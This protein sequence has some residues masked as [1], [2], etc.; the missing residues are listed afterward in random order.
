MEAGRPEAAAAIWNWR[1]D[2]QASAPSARSARWRG[3]LR[4]ALVASVGLLLFAFWSTRVGA[5][6]CIVAGVIL[7]SALVSPTGL[8]AGVE[9]LF[10]ALGKWTGQA[11]TWIV[12]VPLFYLFFLPFGL[13]LR[14]GRRDRLKRYFESDAPSYWEPHEG[15]TASSASR[16][17][18]Y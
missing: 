3:V 17:R 7:F 15:P 10:A 12:M 5:V 16:V 8:Y 1:E 2:A 4:G 18:Q 13:L 11:L 9:G 6:V 14:R